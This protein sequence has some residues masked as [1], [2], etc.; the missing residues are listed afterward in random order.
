M[1][2]P[3]RAHQPWEEGAG[4]WFSPVAQEFP[5]LFPAFPD[6]DHGLK[7]EMTN[8]ESFAVRAQE[9]LMS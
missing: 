7:F 1:V 5:L 3:A 9:P 2:M 4:K 8:S 6:S